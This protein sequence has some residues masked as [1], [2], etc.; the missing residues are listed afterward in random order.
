MKM[1]NKIIA[2]CTILIIMGI[3]V[4]QK[5]NYQVYSKSNTPTLFTKIKNQDRHLKAEIKKEEVVAGKN[6]TKQFNDYQK[7]FKTY[8]GRVL[9][10]ADNQSI[11][12]FKYKNAINQNWKDL[13]GA[14][15]LKY[16]PEGTKVEVNYEFP[17]T[18]VIDREA[19]YCEQVIITYKHKNGEETTF[20]ALV[21]SQSGLI[22]DTWDRNLS[23]N[24]SKRIPSSITLSPMENAKT[25]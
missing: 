1:N 19:I 12:H 2:F 23:E 6:I 7:R 18:K 9:V 20:R 10:G 22:E 5:D 25:Y 13:L 8:E 3:Y 11:S 17:V 16:Q 14:D 24:K 4:V 21:N 15:L